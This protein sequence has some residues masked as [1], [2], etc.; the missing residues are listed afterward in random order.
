MYIGTLCYRDGYNYRNLFLKVQSDVK[1]RKSPDKT[2]H[3]LMA[4]LRTK[5]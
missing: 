2:F 4:L 5:S 1:L 3:V